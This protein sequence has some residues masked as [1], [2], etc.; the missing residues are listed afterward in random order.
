MAEIT[1]QMVL[2]TLQ[3]LSIIVG[4][5]YYALTLR[6]QTMTRKGQ[7]LMQTFARID[8]PS[9]QKAL[10]A[11][12]EMKFENF[13]EFM[14]KYGPE[15]GTEYWSHIGTMQ[16]FT[17]ILGGMVRENYIGIEG[18]ATLIGGAMIYYWK[19]MEPIHDQLTEYLY[20]RW[21]IETEYLY[22]ELTKY[23]KKHPELKLNS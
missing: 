19:L 4:I 6:N 23:G 22:K 20:P 18:I 5:S 12:F 15:S 2:S 16:L 1:Y 11:I 21:N 13:D 3:T 14:E 10:L 7:L 8:T 17:E 9:R